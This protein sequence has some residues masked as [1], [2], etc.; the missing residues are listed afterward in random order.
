MALLLFLEF[1]LELNAKEIVCPIYQ[2]AQ[3]ASLVFNARRN[4]GDNN[5]KSIFE[6]YLIKDQISFLY[7]SLI[8]TNLIN[9]KSYFCEDICMKSQYG[10]TYPFQILSSASS[11]ERPG[12]M[13]LGEQY[14]LVDKNNIPGNK[15]KKSFQIVFK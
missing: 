10:T 8:E 9:I 13:H 14:R 11:R 6:T 4:S 12:A 3:S 15:E 5:M 7:C 1:L 2:E